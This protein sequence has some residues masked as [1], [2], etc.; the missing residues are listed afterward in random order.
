MLYFGISA[1]LMSLGGLAIGIGMM[2][3]A[4][5]VMVENIF[6]C[7]NENRDP[8]EPGIH[9]VARSAREVARP[10]FFG[11][12]IIILV[13]L[14]LFTLRGVEGTMFRPLAYTIALAMLGSLLFALTAAPCSL[15]SC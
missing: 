10:V 1:N 9:I 4:S 3:D 14:P 2:V 15:R 5:V 11:I 6:R 13:F 7:L 8:D 12:T